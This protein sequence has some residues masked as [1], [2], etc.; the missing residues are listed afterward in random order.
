MGRNVGEEKARRLTRELENLNKLYQDVKAGQR[1]TLTY[2]PGKGVEIA[3]D[4]KVLG[5]VP[6]AEF[7]AA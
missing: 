3:M 2:L 4:G 7:A 1:Y 6:G 5:L